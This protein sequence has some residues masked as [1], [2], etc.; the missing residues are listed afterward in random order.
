MEDKDLEKLF[1][2]LM[3]DEN[4][5]EKLLDIVKQREYNRGVNSVV[6]GLRKNKKVTVHHIF[7]KSR[8]HAVAEI[9]RLVGDKYVIKL[10]NR[11][12]QYSIECI[13]DR[14]VYLYPTDSSRGYRCHYA[15]IDSDLISTDA[16]V[17]NCLIKPSVMPLSRDSERNDCIYYY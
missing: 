10:V 9:N 1:S 5:V 4:S 16:E 8:E 3:K 12:D 7:S 6:E 14:Y 11:R 15:H 17:I 13:Y 2:M